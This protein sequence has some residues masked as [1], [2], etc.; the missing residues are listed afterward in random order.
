MSSG[1]AKGSCGCELAALLCPSMSLGNQELTAGR[2]RG[3]GQKTGSEGRREE[4]RENAQI[5]KIKKTTVRQP[6]EH[7]GPVENAQLH[8]AGGGRAGAVPGPWLFVPLDPKA[9]PH[10]GRRLGPANSARLT[11][12]RGSPSFDEC[13]CLKSPRYGIPAV[14]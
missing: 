8:T 2:G 4:E 14:L 11:P 1:A 3:G 13:L 7:I 12:G 10:Q 5:C 6:R 9:D